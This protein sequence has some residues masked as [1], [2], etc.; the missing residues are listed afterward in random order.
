MSR[1]N[2]HTATPERIELMNSHVKISQILSRSLPVVLALALLVP[3]IS[4]AQESE[5]A[6]S[7]E[8]AKIN[9]LK[10]EEGIKQAQESDKKVFIDFYT[11]R[12]GWCK[13]MDR[14]TFTDA[15]VIDYMNTNFVSV[16]VNGGSS[17][18]LEVEG[19]KTNE[20]Q[21]ASQLYGVRGYPTYWFLEPDGSKIGRQPGY[22]PAEQFLQLLAYV[23]DEQYKKP[24]EEQSANS[25]GSNK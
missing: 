7:A 15:R 19:F 21:I 11:D 12:C 1:V 4:F 16:K 8:E 6:D 2:G 9:W 18:E 3:S 25:D 20:R 17:R 10:Y 5:K 22:Q 23:K 13:K 24:K 14:E